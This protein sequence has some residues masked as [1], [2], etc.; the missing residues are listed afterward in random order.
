M[1]DADQLCKDYRTNDVVI[2]LMKDWMKT[3]SPLWS[4]WAKMLTESSPTLRKYFYDYEI[5]EHRIIDGEEKF[6]YALPE[7][8]VISVCRSRMRNEVVKLT[9]QIAEPSVMRIE[10]DVSSTFTE[11]LGVIGN[12][13]MFL[14]VYNL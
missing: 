12:K 3:N 10:K 8:E 4:Y 14:P 13:K 2:K 7:T 1:L 6:Y 11:Q 9:V 5:P